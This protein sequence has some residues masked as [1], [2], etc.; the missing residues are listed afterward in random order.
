MDR[1]DPSTQE[2]SILRAWL[3]ATALLVLGASLARASTINPRWNDCPA[4]PTASQLVTFPC[5]DDTSTFRLVRTLIS[6][7]IQGIYL[8]ASIVKFLNLRI[9]STRKSIGAAPGNWRGD[10]VS[11]STGAVVRPY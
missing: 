1:D 6:A 2:A 9:G 8:S 10:A 3:F 11:T 4:G 7:T 5:N